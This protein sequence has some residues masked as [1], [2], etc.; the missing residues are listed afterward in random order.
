M[1]SMSLAGRK[2][3]GR[4]LLSQLG[5]QNIK[6]V[7]VVGSDFFLVFVYIEVFHA[8]DIERLLKV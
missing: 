5:V 6:E 3:G 4:D 1:A 2:R 7:V 8:G